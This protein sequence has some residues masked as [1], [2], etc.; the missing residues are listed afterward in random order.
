VLAL[1]L[2]MDLAIGL[3]RPA[4]NL[5]YSCH[6]CAQSK[7]VGTWVSLKRTVELAADGRYGSLAAISPSWWSLDERRVFIDSQFGREIHTYELRGDVLI[8]DGIRF[9]RETT[10][11]RGGG[12]LHSPNYA[13]FHF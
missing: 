3:P 5:R 1:L 7:L 9:R 6:H 12:V 10:D 2:A 4:T 8:F 13:L 11:S